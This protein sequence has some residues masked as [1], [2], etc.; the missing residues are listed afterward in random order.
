MR[1][2]V[3]D[4]MGGGLGKAV[5]ETIHAAIPD[6]LIIALGTNALATS[7]MLRAGANMG[8]TGENAI[9][10]NCGQADYIVGA[11]GIILVNA[12]LGEIS[13]RI[14]QAVSESAARKIL[15]NA[16]KCGVNIVG[17]AEKPMAQYIAEVPD[18]IRRLSAE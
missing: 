3:I 18:I 11:I 9:A 6:A 17:T 2:L 15:I 13:P 7:A 4:G 14:A 1:I 12:M 5:V 8:A 16:P 10:F